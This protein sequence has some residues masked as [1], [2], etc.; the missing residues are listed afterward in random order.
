M[1]IKEYQIDRYGPLTD[2]GVIKLGDFTLLFGEN[3][4][5]KSLTIDAMVKMLFQTRKEQKCFSK[6]S[7]V[8]EHPTGYLRI[9]SNN[10]NEV[11]LPDSGDITKVTGL[12]AEECRNIFIIRN[13]N[14]SIN[15]ESRFYSTITNRLTGLRTEEIGSIKEKLKEYGRLTKADSNASLANSNSSQYIAKKV[16]DAEEL[17]QRIDGLQEKIEEK[18][19]GKLEREISE[20]EEELE[21]LNIH[22]ENMEQ[23]DKRMKYENSMNAIESLE[24][25]L[26]KIKKL[27]LFTKEGEQKWRDAERD[28]KR[29]KEEKEKIEKQIKEEEK[30]AEYRKEELD[31]LQ[32]T[33]SPMEEKKKKADDELKADLKHHNKMK[34]K[35]VP[36]ERLEQTLTVPAIISSIMA[37]LLAVALFIFSHTVITNL[38][39]T[40]S[41][42]AIFLWILKGFFASGRGRLE[43]DFNRIKT[44]ASQLGLHA[45]DAE[46]IYASL[47]SFENEYNKLKDTIHDKSNTLNSS[48]ER[49]KN[50]RDYDL[51]EKEAN[52]EKAEGI[53][54]DL[55]DTSGVKELQEYQQ[56]LKEKEDADKE[57]NEQ[58]VI[59]RNYFGESREGLEMNLEKWKQEIEKLENFKDKALGVEYNEERYHTLKQK[60]NVLDERKETC[61][62][63]LHTFRRELHEIEAEANRI[64]E[65]DNGRLV[66]SSSLD[67]EPIKNKLSTFAKEVQ[68]R[69]E[70][71][72]QVISFFEQIEE[73]EEQKVQ[74][75]FGENSL[76]SAYFSEITDGLYQEVHFL[77]EERRIEVKKTSSGK[78]IEAEKLSSGA[79]DQLYLSIR[80]AL[81]HNLLEGG[82]GFFIMDDPFIKAD[83]TRLKR[84][85]DILKKIKEMGW[86]VIYFSAKDEVKECLEDEIKEQRITYKEIRNIV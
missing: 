51:R 72:K 29:N 11:N 40:F 39:I 80:L 23:A 54:E 4:K 34:E 75:L 50:W 49:I 18:G 37:P 63:D 58:R 30:K 46:G 36:L 22:I 31:D 14:L 85:L 9:E 65:Q 5:G 27:R 32:R 86:Q 61:K 52:I 3:E 1:R 24:D 84:Q 66:C 19:Y 62:A 68:E 83:R 26:E 12:S 82:R 70:D 60:R 69:M 13:S 28:K 67:L 64:I 74:E 33:F 35:R 78:S 77:S 55:Q 76:A 71:A 10:G 56:K 25:A 81:G 21:A 79:Y 7:R 8:D 43:S 48:E 47:D 57:S 42:I 20:A 45:E 16:K 41:F 17:I 44:F 15:E 73:E 38:L 6:V 2:T 59:L 53:I